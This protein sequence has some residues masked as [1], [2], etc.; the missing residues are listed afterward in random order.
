MNKK[1]KFLI[2]IIIAINGFFSN[3]YAQQSIYIKET[4]GVLT[5]IPLTQIQKITFSATDMVLHKTDAS[6]ISWATSDVQ[7]YYYDLTTG[8]NNIGVSENNDVLI[9]P[10]P[11]NGNF[12]INYHIKEQGRVNIYI[13]SIDG[14][15]KRNL[16][17]ENK[18]QGEYLLNVSQY[19]EAGYYLVK[20]ESNNKFSTKKII[21]LK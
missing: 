9:Y 10:N 3:I 1:G 6:I 5:Q 13:I 14:K 18:E 4:N 11:S 12:N 19:L 17:S 16:L 7:K 21:I 15:I 2:A 8:I 20:I